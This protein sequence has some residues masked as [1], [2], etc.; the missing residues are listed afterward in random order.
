MTL[1]AQRWQGDD[2]VFPVF[3]GISDVPGRP[4]LS[5][6][7][8]TVARLSSAP[9]ADCLTPEATYGRFL[10]IRTAEQQVKV[11]TDTRPLPVPI[12]AIFDMASAQHPQQALFRCSDG[13]VVSLEHCNTNEVVGRQLQQGTR[14]THSMFEPPASTALLTTLRTPAYYPYFPSIYGLRVAVLT[15]GGKNK[16]LRW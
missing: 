5:L 9:F 7:R 6:D 13:V 14:K 3:A 2:L 15:F 10:S 12:P 8:F 4:A 1:E 11:P 16:R